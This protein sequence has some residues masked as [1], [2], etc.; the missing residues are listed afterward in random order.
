MLLDIISKE[1]IFYFLIFSISNQNN[2]SKLETFLKQIGTR[3]IISFSKFKKENRCCKTDGFWIF[4][5]NFSDP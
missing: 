4:F 5:V 1:T 2:E 3:K